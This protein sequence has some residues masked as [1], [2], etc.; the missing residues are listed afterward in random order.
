LNKIAKNKKHVG[1]KEEKNNSFGVFI[2]TLYLLKYLF[3]KV[4]N[5]RIVVKINNTK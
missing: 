4:I 1:N 3:V 2:C 5:Q